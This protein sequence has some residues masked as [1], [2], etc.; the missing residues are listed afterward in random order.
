MQPEANKAFAAIGWV[1]PD[2]DQLLGAIQSELNK[3]AEEQ[4]RS[5]MEQASARLQNT[6]SKLN[7][8]LVLLNAEGAGLLTSELSAS[9]QSVLEEGEE[10]REE[11]LSSL[12]QGSVVLNHYLDWLQAGQ[13]DLPLILLPALNELRAARNAPLM[14]EG[15]LFSPDL[16]IADG[17]DWSDGGKPVAGKRLKSFAKTKRDAYESALA[18]WLKEPQD[19]KSLTRL[20][21]TAA[22][23]KQ[24][25]NET[26]ERRLWWFAENLFN[27]LAGGEI[28]NSIALRRLFA[29]LDLNL[30][31]IQQGESPAAANVDA[32]ASSLLFYI[33]TARSGNSQLDN[34][35]QR[36]QLERLVPDRKW[37][38][39]TQSGLGARN[40][41]FYESIRSALEPEL[42]AIKDY[43]DLCRRT[44]KWPDGEYQPID[45]QL[46]KLADT[47]SVLGLATASQSMRDQLPVWR[48]AIAAG[49][50]PTEAEMVQAA[51]QLL[52]AESALEQNLNTLGGA[53]GEPDD[54]ALPFAE[55]QDTTGQL[56][57]ECVRELREIEEELQSWLEG[58][59]NKK[60]ETK[61]D[62]LFGRIGSAFAMLNLVP[63]AAAVSQLK[64]Y[65][66]DL[67][68]GQHK[69]D[70]DDL[71]D[72]ADALVALEHYLIEQ[73]DSR[74]S[75]DALFEILQR[76]LRTIRGD[77]PEDQDSAEQ[78]TAKP[79]DE[80]VPAEPAADEQVAEAAAEE[81]VADSTAPAVS[82]DDEVLEIFLEEYEAVNQELRI[83]LPNWIADP[84]VNEELTD[85]RRAFHTL[86]G[87]GR[88]VGANEIGEFSW[89][90][91]QLLNQVLDGNR[92]PD[93]ELFSAVN[94]GV[95]LLPALKA[96]LANQ[97]HELGDNIIDA[98]KS[99]MDQFAGGGTFDAGHLRELLPPQLSALL[100]EAPAE[101]EEAADI[102]PGLADI[103]RS[104]VGEH[105]KLLTVFVGQLS[106]ENPDQV[107]GTAEIRAAHTIAGNLSLA[108]VGGESAV[109]SQLE[110]LL[111]SQH[112]NAMPL[113]VESRE[114]IGRAIAIAERR[115][116]QL[117]VAPGSVQLDI[118]DLAAELKAATTALEAEPAEQDDAIEPGEDIQSIFLDEARDVLER[119]DSLL[120][121]WRDGLERDDPDSRDTVVALQREIHTLKGGARMCGLNAI[122][123]LS[124]AMETLL[125]QV[126]DGGLEA[127]DRIV[128]SLENG[129]DELVNLLDKTEA[130]EKPPGTDL[131][132]PHL[133]ELAEAA[134]PAP[135]PEPEPEPELEPEP[136]PVADTEVH[137][138]IAP[139]EIPDLPAAP[140]EIRA[141][142][143]G[144]TDAAEAKQETVRVSAD[145]L[146]ELVNYAGEISI[147]RS[148]LE[149][150]TNAFRFN[151]TEINQTITRLRDQ[152]RKMEIETETQILSRFQRETDHDEAVFDPLE[153]D[154][155]STLQQLSRALAESVSDLMNL[156]E[157]LDDTARQS[158]TL[159]LQQSRVNT[160]LQEGLMQARMVSFANLAPRLR[161]LVRRAAKE[162]KKDARLVLQLAGGSD[163]QLDRNVLER[164]TAPLEHLLRNAIVHGIE[165]PAQR[166]RR[167]KPKDG[168]IA[169]TVENEATELVITVEDDGGGIDLPAIRKQAIERE[170]ISKNDNPSD[171]ELMEFILE[172]G[173]TTAEELT[174]L[175]GRGI[176]MDVVNNEI[177]QIGGS[178]DIHSEQGEGTRFTIRIPFTLA[179]MQAITVLAGEREF[180][181]PLAS[182]R[183]VAKLSATEYRERISSQQPVYEFAGEPF[184]ILELEPQLG[185]ESTDITED[186]VSL[187]MIRAGEQRAAFRPVELYTHREIVIKPVGP[188]ISSIPGILGGTITGD[189]RVMLILD[190]GPLIRRG[191]TEALRPI[192][193]PLPV[194]AA[195]E[196]RKRTP[197]VMV[198][199]DSITMRKVTSRVLENS[200]YEVLTAKDGL[201]AVEQLLE[202][203]PDVML[204]D[205]EMPRMDG[206]ELAEHV[207]ADT[208]LRHIPLVMITSRT[209]KKH[210]DRA[211]QLGVN[212]YLTKPYQEQDLLN[213]VSE[214]L[215]SQ[216]SNAE[217]EE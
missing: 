178:V 73:R 190:M 40:R 54:D 90:I 44:G 144:A 185:F 16:T 162:S 50:L 97:E 65:T 91:E 30:K 20:A 82:I 84:V 151:L 116:E 140:R 149:Q 7:D 206:Y 49:E 202:R 205:I 122:G 196:E 136:E 158:E 100:P 14:S 148:R 80:Q 70:Q 171:Q 78:E 130:G 85:I 211:E 59:K 193:K 186:T 161:R 10:S 109:F 68:N 177:K 25:L 39:R 184:P 81:P 31:E 51:E 77:A 53:I 3:A 189:G 114:L 213:C 74:H 160:E 17:D 60:R 107:A 45:I 123:D 194:E 108:P 165:T 147:Y 41:E 142:P 167:K 55:L 146:D 110:R 75:D 125:E 104:E 137:E 21:E 102:D 27:G 88:M 96:R 166:K 12:M 174:G 192:A 106:G 35:K 159:L 13:P 67:L 207:R 93:Q 98:V 163:G 188:Q 47:M 86:K 26:R 33:G 150:Q 63:Q 217:L 199:D 6:L 204:L 119:S 131:I 208:R 210:R 115:L 48:E 9:W 87:S 79:D 175:A 99:A 42:E 113:P 155:Y 200:D 52:R 129:C 145:L 95:A 36:F 5:V 103:I 127:G 37:L 34:I 24:S 197:L 181:I 120:H 191:I 72:Y 201:D 135:E 139:I 173:F 69:T 143:E 62:Q 11:L 56:W 1:R 198:V 38:S 157:M 203:V 153:M 76:R 209:G 58:T 61:I 57:Q 126:A 180:A 71:D 134:K 83:K 169:I 4:D 19:Q 64:E 138:P 8:T 212:R 43:F 15:V 101:T 2:L 94:L 183:G 112:G 164:I 29:R 117:D 105:L 152:L 118:G 195:K 216:D 214:M 128:R 133:A 89:S 182:V 66:A 18:N 22:T 187:L 172:S 124:H 168:E 170:L 215:E 46:E 28:S 179:V 92:A 132:Q 121:R 111:E 154:R 156:E 141:M 176:G 32:L 23:L